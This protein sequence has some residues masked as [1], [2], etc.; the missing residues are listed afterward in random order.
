MTIGRD[1]SAAAESGPGPEDVFAI[2]LAPKLRRRV[3]KNCYVTVAYRVNPIHILPLII[4]KSFKFDNTS[5]SLHHSTRTTNLT[6]SLAHFDTSNKTTKLFRVYSALT[7]ISISSTNKT[8]VKVWPRNH[9]TLL[10]K[11]FLTLA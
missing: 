9:G 5:R 2:G 6:R 7:D 10:A 8:V 11:S 3:H 4:P 1:I